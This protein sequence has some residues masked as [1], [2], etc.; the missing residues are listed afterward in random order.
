MSSTCRL[1][2]RNNV[3]FLSLAKSQ[4]GPVCDLDHYQHS[5]PA[6]TSHYE[7][8]FSS[9]GLPEMSFQCHTQQP[10]AAD[11]RELTQIFKSL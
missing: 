1:K 11:F 10:N 2:I 3:Q 6:R 4:G 9:L 5:G 8:M 7:P